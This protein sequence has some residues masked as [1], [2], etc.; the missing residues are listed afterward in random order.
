[1]SLPILMQFQLERQGLGYWYVDLTNPEPKTAEYRE[2]GF[3]SFRVCLW[4]GTV[5][6]PRGLFSTFWIALVLDCRTTPSSF[7]LPKWD[8]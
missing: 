1:M 3:A 7:G 2:L 5:S 8:L 6:F 4:H